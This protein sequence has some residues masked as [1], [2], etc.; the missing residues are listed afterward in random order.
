M[1]LKNECKPH[2]IAQSIWENMLYRDDFKLEVQS[3]CVSIS[4]HVP[5][6]QFKSKHYIEGIW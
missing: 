4:S 1:G 5:L 6:K 2:T 3:Y